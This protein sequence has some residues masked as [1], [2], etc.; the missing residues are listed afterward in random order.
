MTKRE[1]RKPHNTS[2]LWRRRVEVAV[3][4]ARKLVILGSAR[5]R[6]KSHSRQTHGRWIFARNRGQM[7]A[8][9]RQE[10][11]KKIAAK[12][13]QAWGPKPPVKK[14]SE[15]ERLARQAEYAELLFKSALRRIERP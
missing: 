11:Q 14:V 5:T 12:F 3:L 6:T 7:W 13:E 15:E 9:I 4:I 10:L 2:D 1:S 8:E